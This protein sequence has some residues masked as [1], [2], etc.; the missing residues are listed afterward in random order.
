MDATLNWVSILVVAFEI[1]QSRMSSNTCDESV[2]S[3]FGSDGKRV[4]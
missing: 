3:P 2:G 1:N 4:I